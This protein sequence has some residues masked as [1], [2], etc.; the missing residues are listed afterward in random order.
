MKVNIGLLLVGLA[1]FAAGVSM[2]VTQLKKKKFNT[3]AATAEIIG[4]HVEESHRAKD[5]SVVYYPVLRYYAAGQWYEERGDVGRGK[6]TYAV[7]DRV[8]VFY[9]PQKPESFYI[10]GDKSSLIMAV[11]GL[12]L[13]A[14]VMILSFFAD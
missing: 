1:F 3:A 8:E 6:R 2:L 4:Y 5:H 13:G 9:N 12:L 11:I 7:G 14:G 10:L